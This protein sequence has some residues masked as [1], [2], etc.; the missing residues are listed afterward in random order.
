MDATA[1]ACPVAGRR[2]DTYT[3]V[4]Q[5]GGYATAP[6]TASPLMPSLARAHTQYTSSG[7]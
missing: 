5:S 4:V 7:A 2:V 6:A 3:L 1:H